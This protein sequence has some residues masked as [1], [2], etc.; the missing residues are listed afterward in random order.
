MS[1][2]RCI[3]AGVAPTA[4]PSC[5]SL[6]F[7][8]LFLWS[9]GRR[10]QSALIAATSPTSCWPHRSTGHGP[11][12]K[13]PRKC[14]LYLHVRRVSTEPPSGPFPRNRRT[15]DE[16]GGAATAFAAANVG[17]SRTS[18][19]PAELSMRITTCT[20]QQ[21]NQPTDAAS[22]SALA[23]RH[24]IAAFVALSRSPLS[25]FARNAAADEAYHRD[26]PLTVTQ[27]IESSVRLDEPPIRLDAGEQRAS[28]HR[29]LDRRG[30]W[31]W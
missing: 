12:I 28:R 2:Y 15:D 13:R 5:C 19:L 23:V 16:S 20:T 7:V 10:N 21:S 8:S 22:R 11:R 17:S 3:G 14:V 1:P 25:F 26:Q 27:V 18:E 4:S 6:T 30:V 24:R 9:H 31:R 29:Q